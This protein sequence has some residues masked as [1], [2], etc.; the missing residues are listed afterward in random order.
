MGN[1]AVIVGGNHQ[2]T[3]GVIKALGQ[4]GVFSKVIVWADIKESYV[5]SSKYVEQGWV[6]KTEDEI[7][8]ILK[9]KTIQTGSKSVVIACCDDAAC[10]LNSHYN[11]LSDWYVLPG[12]E[13][14]GALG[15]WLNKERMSDVAQSLGMVIPKSWEITKNS[16]LNE[17]SYPCVTKPI[18]SEK[19]GK[20]GF[21][22]CDS[23]EQLKLYLSDISTDSK[24]QVQQFIDKDFE[25]QFLGC[26][27]NGGEKVIIPG[28]THIVITTGFNNLVFLRY[29]KF[30]PVLNDIVELCKKFVRYTT[31]SGLFSIEFMRGKDGK[32]YFLEM[33]FRND[34][35]GIAVT[36]SGINLPYIWYLGANELD[37]E[38][39]IAASNVKETFMMPEI[40]FFMSMLQGEITFKE[41]V[42]DLK[43]T[44]VFLTYSKDDK[45]P[46]RKLLRK[47]T[48]SIL[49]QILLLGLKRLHLYDFV[50]RIKRKLS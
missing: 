26:S 20:H 24:V 3:L 35:N 19:N 25:F 45:A 16:N 21:S 41:Y 38:K 40:S 11:E 22:R 8:N 32:D 9:S 33:N 27:I 49:T 1:S 6:C 31:Y 14:E 5:L 34:G 2:N 44:T 18:T 15:P 12:I 39:E 23:Q 50:R 10:L 17:I 37:V 30:E 43:K 46:F 7:L 29:G 42:R 28:R 13:E 4:K 47:S 36:A 48:S